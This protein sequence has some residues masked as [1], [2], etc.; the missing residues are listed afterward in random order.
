[1]SLTVSSLAAH[2]QSTIALGMLRHFRA[3]RI[4]AILT[5]LLLLAAAGMKAHQLLTHPVIMEIWLDWRPFQI[6]W[7]NVEILLGLALVTGL[8]PRLSWGVAVLSFT[9]F[10]GVTVWKAAIGAESCGCFGV[11]T[12]DPRITLVMDIAILAALL[13]FRPPPRHDTDHPPPRTGFRHPLGKAVIALWLLTSIPLTVATALYT[14]SQL[15]SDGTII[16]SSGMVVLQPAAWTGTRL[17]L[18]P[19]IVAEAEV[20]TG[21]WTVVLYRHDCPHCRDQLPAAVADLRAKGEGRVALIQVPPRSPELPEWLPPPAPDLT[22]GALNGEREWFVETPTF[23]TLNHGA[24][25]ATVTTGGSSAM[26]AMLHDADPAALQRL[27]CT[28]GRMDIGYIAPEETRT[29]LAVCPNPFDGDVRI[30]HVRSECACLEAILPLEAAVGRDGELLIPMAFIAPE[31]ATV[32]DKRVLLVSAD[33]PPLT[34]PLRVTAAVGIA[35]TC[36]PPVPQTEPLLPEESDRITVRLH[37]HLDKD[38]RLLYAR[39]VDRSCRVA[40]PREPLPAHGQLD[41]E[42]RVTARGQRT[43]MTQLSITTDLDEHPTIRVPIRV[44][45]SETATTNTDPDTGGTEGG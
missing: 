25:V 5:G 1:M 24:Q 18:I 8:W 4:V 36:S 45:G 20:T 22:H 10:T 23:L 39:S 19:H 26:R 33:S 27:A 11:V 3:H 44:M 41:L 17:P 7:L 42:V 35:V 43:R 31:S 13:V 9:A 6:A 32:Y 28:D 37:N 30:S 2:G 29:F 12:V 21:R 14:P 34:R 38:A 40:I 15:A 16:G